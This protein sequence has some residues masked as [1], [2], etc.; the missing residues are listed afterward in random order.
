[1]K[2]NRVQIFPDMKNVKRVMT[3]KTL[4][5][6]VMFA[7][8]LW[9]YTNLNDTNVT[10]VDVPLTILLPENRAV[11]NEMPESASAEFRGT[12]WNLFT[13]KYF[14]S[15]ARCIVDLSRSNNLDTLYKISRSEMM[16][17]VKYFLDVEL[18]DV[19][20]E[21]INLK[22]GMIASKMVAVRALA[23]I[24]TRSGFVQVGDVVSVPDSI[25]ITGNSKIVDKINDVETRKLLID[26][27][28]LP[29]TQS[30]AMNDINDAPIQINPDIVKLSVDIQQAADI[31]FDDI[32]IKIKGGRLPKG[33]ILSPD[34][35]KVT[36]FG[37]INQ[38]VDFSKD[39]IEITVSY[40]AILKD[41]TGVLIPK[42][43]LPRGL[44]LIRTEPEYI[45]HYEN[46]SSSSLV[47]Y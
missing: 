1:M 29:F 2:K 13:L 22:T 23:N 41:S 39:D 8:A 43:Q 38:L 34:L 11:E 20:P 42:I 25:E 15:T 9:M 10:R 14:N 36:V 19:I 27:A 31:T 45:Y 30:I 26:D 46:I 21:N 6:S 4:L 7:F 44:K 17:S 3:S 18:M 24:K 5:G 35:I 12:G 16:K 37:G 28:H 33:H 40:E 47:K 32:K